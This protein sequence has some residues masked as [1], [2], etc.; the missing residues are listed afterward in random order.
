[1]RPDRGIVSELLGANT[2]VLERHA[3]SLNADARRVQDIRTMAQL[4]VTELQKGW[5]GAD[6]LRLTQ[7]W[8]SHAS[9]L[10]AG[11]AA[12]LETCAAELR[13][14]SS[15]QRETS[16]QNDGGGGGAGLFSVGL[17]SIPSGLA[18]IPSGMAATP[19]VMSCLPLVP[20][21]PAPKHGSPAANATWWRSMSPRQQSQVISE[22]PDWIGNRDGVTFSARDLANR[23]LL[24]VDRDRLVVV[25]QRLEAT[26]AG[27]WSGSLV[28]DGSTAL[29]H[30]RNKLASLDAIEATLAGPGE[31]QLLLLDLGQERAQA[32]LAQGSVDTA[33]NVAVFVPGMMSTVSESI[34]GFDQEM[35]Q[36]RHKADLASTWVNPTQTAAT[37]ATVTWI[38]YQTPREGWDL[39]SSDRSAFSTTLARHGAARLAPFL[40]GIGAARVRDA[41]LTLLGHSYGSTTAALALRQNTG[42]DDAVFFGSP[43]LG[44]SHLE[45]LRIADG[46]AYYIE[47]GQDPVGDLGTLG[48]DPSHLAGLQHASARAATVADPQT[49]EIRHLTG[50]TGH[51]SYLLDGSTS[52]YNMSVVVG[53]VPDRR[54]YDRGEGIGDLLSWPAP[55]AY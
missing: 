15:A 1:M 25:R 36:L 3:E 12:T 40:Q 13:V 51:S 17:T 50:V 49:G 31:R 16:S 48:I 30:V 32:A 46:H 29:D 54:L 52:Q 22:H 45:D 43:G 38:G 47:A 9:P 20:A 19:A 42:V 21:A 34:Q 28:T 27:P 33:E 2:D 24:T 23:A 8:E 44:T 18:S 53:G 55:G 11:A 37:T 4:A 39:L 41:H 6:L 7:Q 14:Q 5:Q 26:M 10:L 35:G